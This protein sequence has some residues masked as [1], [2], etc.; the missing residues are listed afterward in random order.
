MRFSKWIVATIFTFSICNSGHLFAQEKRNTKPAVKTRSKEAA[1]AKTGSP[2]DSVIDALYAAHTFEQTAIA[3]DGTKV[4]WVETLVDTAKLKGDAAVMAGRWTGETLP[5]ENS[6]RSAE[7]LVD[8]LRP[9]VGRLN[10]M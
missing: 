7:L 1:K 5:L 8:A 3:P 2:L 6:E 4:A 10:K 9:N